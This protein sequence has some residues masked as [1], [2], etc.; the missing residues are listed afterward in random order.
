MNLTNSNV[1]LY[2]GGG[3]IG[4]KYHGLVGKLFKKVRI[5]VV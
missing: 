4:R 3:I 2:G 1:N 5:V